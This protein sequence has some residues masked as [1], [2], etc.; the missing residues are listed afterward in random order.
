MVA[1]TRL[2]ELHG[3]AMS[4][5][6]PERAA[7]FLFSDSPFSTYKYIFTRHNS[8]ITR[9]EDLSGRSAGVLRGN[10]ADVKLLR[11]WPGIR[12]VEIDT[13]V[14]LAVALQN[15][16]LDA[17]ISSASLHW[18][19]NE[20]LLPGI[21][22]V[23]PVPGS[24]VELRYSILKEHAPLL[25]IINKALAAIRPEEI[26]KI[27]EK[28]GARQGPAIDLSAE[29]RAWIAANPTIRLGAYALAPYI[30][31]EKGRVDGYL[32][33]LLQAIAGQAGLRAEFYFLTL[34][35]VLDG[36]QRGELDATM[37]VSHTKKREEAFLLSQETVDFTLDIFA[38]KVT[39]DIDS[40]ESLVGKTLATYEGY[41]WNS[42]FA[43]YLP[44]TRI[45]TAANIGDIFRMVATGQADAAINELESGKALLRRYLFTNVEPKA[46][47][48]FAG[49]RTY[50]GHYYRVSK[51]LPLLASILDKSQAKLLAAEKQ[52]I[53]DR[54]FTQAANPG[55][56][57]LSA[58]ERA[59]LDA[60]VFRRP[61]STDWMPFDFDDADGTPIGIG[62]DY[63]GLIRDKLG[64]KEIT[65]DRRSFSAILVAMEHGKTDLY[66]ATT[67]TGDREKYA[68]FSDAYENYP[69]A[70]ATAGRAG[71]ITSAASLEGRPA[72]VGRNYSA[73]HL[74]KALYPGIEFVLVDSTRDALDEVAAGTA[75]AAVDILP[76][77]HQQIEELPAGSVKLAGVTDVSAAGDARQPTHP[78]DPPD[79]SRH[80]RFHAGGTGGLSQQVD[81]A[82]SHHR[83]GLHPLVAGLGDGFVD[84]ADHAV[85]EPQA[86]AGSLAPQT[87][88][89][90]TVPNGSRV[91][92]SQGERR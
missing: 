84:P 1:R 28:W 80:R 72:A 5:K 91:V 74:L 90:F 27:L 75:Y 38:R 4:A 87:G 45:L 21:R 41:S 10:L 37:A 71:L 33:E 70:I 9:M 13:T 25:G 39:R 57:E 40:V 51:R 49:K 8:P 17:A 6:H 24:K 3:L 14:D 18:T 29:E 16:D 63:W 32:V 52:R 47:A 35:E 12:L 23:F 7:R 89:T 42:L 79:Q 81:D 68:V 53:W 50:R 19:V 15:G 77:L 78:P 48:V 64:M 26:Q 69:I 76:A 82:R 61:R 88:R 83:A 92:A 46:D 65:M 36:V 66:A 56:V 59:Y 30:Q 55:E 22:T 60:T 73:Y 34:Q 54:W 2:G 44:H 86:T 85:L 43:K 31:E 62:E 58:E 67:R 20:N 11:N